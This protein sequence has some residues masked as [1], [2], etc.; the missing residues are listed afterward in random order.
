MGQAGS[1]LV[2]PRWSNVRRNESEDLYWK[3]VGG[4]NT[5]WERRTFH[6][7]MTSPLFINIV[8]LL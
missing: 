8:D 7:S 1:V 2:V 5:E 4:K 6:L 3:E